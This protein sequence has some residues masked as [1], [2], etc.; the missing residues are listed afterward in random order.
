M[1]KGKTVIVT[2][3]T[4]GIGLAIAKCFAAHDCN[5]IIN[6]FGDLGEI[7]KITAEL[8]SMTSGKAMHCSANLAESDEIESLV[9]TVIDNF[10]SI[11]IVIN[12]A[13]IQHV[14]PVDKFPIDKWDQVLKVNLTGVFHMTRLALPHM[15][16]A[17][18]GRII[19]IASAHGLVA[20]AHK[21]A[22]VAAKHGVL[23]LTK[24]VALETATEDITCNAVCPGWV[25]TPLVEKQIEDRAKAQGKSVKAAQHELLAEKQPS[26]QFVKPE[27]IAEACCFLSSDAASQITGTS[28]SMDGGWTAV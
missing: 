15:R 28:L 13:G 5:V 24:V 21:A 23:G 4:S 12:N 26:L 27:E 22:Y 8:S 11:D 2:G 9:K 18:W 14:D 17:K 20:S 3:G 6:G 25:L 16:K 7:Q 19:N 10:K 1:L